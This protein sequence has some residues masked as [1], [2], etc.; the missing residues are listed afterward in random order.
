MPSKSKAQ[1][2]LMAA[3]AHGWKP[4]RIDGPP[5]SV[6]KEFN[7]ADTRHRGYSR[8]GLS[9]PPVTLSG[10]A[11]PGPGKGSTLGKT[12][13]VGALG[14][15]TYAGSGL[16]AKPTR[17]GGALSGKTPDR[18][19]G[20]PSNLRPRPGRGVN[21]QLALS[22]TVYH[23]AKDRLESLRKQVSTKKKPSRRSLEQGL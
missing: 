23:E 12:A 10:K 8:G 3:V 20:R 5:L 15:G 19:A 4:D 13:K 11:L 6:A 14:A 21:P 1:A 9:R 16:A 18:V 7:R 17:P 2:R 22:G